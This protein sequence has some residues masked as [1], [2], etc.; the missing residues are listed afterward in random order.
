MPRIYPPEFRCKVLDLVTSGRKVAEVA[1]LLDISDQTNFV[2]PA[3][4]SPI[5]GSCPT[6]PAY[7]IATASLSASDTPKRVLERSRSANC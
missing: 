1:R 4:T 6:S 5:H 7:P 2:W 3:N